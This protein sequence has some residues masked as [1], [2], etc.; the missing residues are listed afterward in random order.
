MKFLQRRAKC[1][2]SRL[3]SH[4]HAVRANF[5]DQR[6]RATHALGG[7]ARAGA[8][9]DRAPRAARLQRCV[10]GGGASG[11]RTI[12]QIYLYRRSFVGGFYELAEIFLKTL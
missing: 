9:G 10:G 12:G 3:L 6:L 4:A 7:G 5:L 2:I 1:D 8:R 11:G